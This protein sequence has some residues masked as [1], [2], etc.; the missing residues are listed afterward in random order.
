MGFEAVLC[1]APLTMADA[2]RD[3]RSIRKRHGIAYGQRR[4]F[5]W[6]RR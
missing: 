1:L 6:L 3:E 4:P 5:D 2:V